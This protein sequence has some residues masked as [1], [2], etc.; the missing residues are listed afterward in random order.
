MTLPNIALRNS[1]FRNYADYMLTEEFQH[2]AAELV[3]MAEQSPHRLHV[4]R[5]RL[6]PLPSHAGVGLADSPRT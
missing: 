4:R 2:A 1:S 3:K 6:F 5:A